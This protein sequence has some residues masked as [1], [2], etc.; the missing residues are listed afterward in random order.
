VVTRWT[1][2]SPAGIPRETFVEPE[3]IRYETFDGDPVTARPVSCPGGPQRF[4]QSCFDC[5]LASRV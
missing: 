2:A 5:W 3:L 4:D 1:D